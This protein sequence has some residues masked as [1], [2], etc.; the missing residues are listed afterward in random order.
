MARQ[1]IFFK[2]QRLKLRY[3]THIGWSISSYL[4]YFL[5]INPR[6]HI[7]IMHHISPALW[8]V[9]QYKQ[10]P[11][12]KRANSNFFDS[13]VYYKQQR[14]YIFIIIALGFRL[15]FTD[16]LLTNIILIWVSIHGSVDITKDQ[17]GLE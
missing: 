9:P 2:N 10:N 16:V 11:L 15:T 12:N 6:N 5:T 13:N 14:L 8:T 7:K 3:S 4:F 17:Q 1:L